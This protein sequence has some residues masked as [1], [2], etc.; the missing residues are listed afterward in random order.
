MRRDV[1]PVEIRVGGAACTAVED[2]TF[3]CEPPP[4]S[5]PRRGVRRG[6]ANWCTVVPGIASVTGDVKITS[7]V[8][9]LV[10]MQ[11]WNSPDI[12]LKYE[13][14]QKSTNPMHSK[15]CPKLLRV[16]GNA[17]GACVSHSPPNAASFPPGSTRLL[18]ARCD[19]AQRLAVSVMNLPV[20]ASPPF[21]WR[22][23]LPSNPPSTAH[24]A[25]TVGPG[26]KSRGCHSGV[27][28]S[29]SA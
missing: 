3:G 5:V 11:D 4:D 20:G 26:S 21:F 16:S 8:F 1:W 2:L 9:Y 12:P 24:S 28:M 17:K 13:E 19:P 18:P 27:R 6:N 14:F 23:V 22:R 29:S 15:I 25:N 7:P 10:Q